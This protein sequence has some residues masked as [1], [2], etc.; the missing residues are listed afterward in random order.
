ML[1]FSTMVPYLILASL[2][3]ITVFHSI[4]L[5]CLKLQYCLKHTLDYSD[6]TLTGIKSY[7]NHNS[8][9]S[10]QAFHINIHNTNF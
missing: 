10:D 1:D 3:V 4:I 6:Q 5:Y 9:K 2:S 8:D 7:I